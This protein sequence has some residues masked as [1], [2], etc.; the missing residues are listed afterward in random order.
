MYTLN[1]YD[2]HAPVY[3][4]DACVSCMSR[5]LFSRASYAIL[6]VIILPIGGGRVAASFLMTAIHQRE[7]NEKD[8]CENDDLLH[9]QQRENNRKEPPAAW[10]GD[11]PLE[12]W[13]LK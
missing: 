3:N 13:K 11:M 7:M 5:D 8:D 2:V 9:S 4:N 10:V 6:W 12:Q 1:N